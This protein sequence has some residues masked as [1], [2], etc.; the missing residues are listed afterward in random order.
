MLLT[1]VNAL[2]PR[3]PM[4]EPAVRDAVSEGR[5]TQITLRGNTPLGF[6]VEGLYRSDSGMPVPAVL[7]NRSGSMKTIKCPERALKYLGKLGVREFEVDVSDWDPAQAFN[8][9]R[10]SYLSRERRRHYQRTM[11]HLRS[12]FPGAMPD[13][14]AARLEQVA[15][16]LAGRH[17]SETDIRALVLCWA[18]VHLASFPQPGSAQAALRRFA[19]EAGLLG[20]N[21][22]ARLVACCDE[23]FKR[24]CKNQHLA[25]LALECGD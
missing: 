23:E 21:L 5:L 7:V 11:S 17:L 6:C 4:P 8:P 12:L 19:G 14:A 18:D 15:N 10:G 24:R 25:S 9:G 13:S 1:D 20:E 3:L 22:G 2:P 16:C